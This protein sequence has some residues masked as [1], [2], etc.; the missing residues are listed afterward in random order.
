[1]S[2]IRLTEWQWVFIQPFLP[3]PAPTGRPQADGRRTI[4]GILYILITGSRWQDQ[5]R[6]Y[7]ALTT[8]WRWLKRWDELRIWERI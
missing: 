5:P 2:R 7:G 3:P 1:M 8:V 6:D 4:E